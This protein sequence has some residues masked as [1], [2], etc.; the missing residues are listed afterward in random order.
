[1]RRS[2]NGQW[3]G[4]LCKG[5]ALPSGTPPEDG[6]SRW[7]PAA[8]GY[9]MLVVSST[10]LFS[11]DA[12]KTVM[13]RARKRDGRCRT[14]RPAP[15]PVVRRPYAVCRNWDGCCSRTCGSRAAAIVCGD[16]P[17]PHRIA[18]AIAGAP[19][20]KANAALSRHTRHRQVAN[21]LF[22]IKSS[23]SID[24]TTRYLPGI[25]TPARRSADMGMLQSVHAPLACFCSACVFFS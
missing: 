16:S 15:A 23:T 2:Y 1:M 4:R 25:A 24:N 10:L 14:K 8:D 3:K 19:Q 5:V 12:W 7:N 11:P 21:Q 20:D 18:V 22:H 13:Q 6:S 17:A 9:N